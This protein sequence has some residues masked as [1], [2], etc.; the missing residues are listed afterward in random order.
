MEYKQVIVVRK[1]LKLSRGK[2]CTQVAHASLGSYKKADG[3]ARSAWESGGSKKV[4]VKAEDLK[5]L[6]EI[7]EDARHMG[8]PCSLIKDAGRTEV[9][10][11]TVTALGI[12]PCKEADMDKITGGLKML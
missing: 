10:P 1:D 6:M 5:S 11:G 2:L 3:R 12:G 7:Y 9:E 8:L 4:V